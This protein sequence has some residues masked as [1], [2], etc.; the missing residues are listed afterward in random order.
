MVLLYDNLTGQYLEKLICGLL[1]V[2]NLSIADI[3]ILF[4]T[5]SIVQGIYFHK[6]K[7]E[8]IFEKII[9]HFVI[10]YMYLKFYEIG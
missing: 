3:H 10:E 2:Q 9:M 5:K 8:G 6:N 7:T 4:M 1:I